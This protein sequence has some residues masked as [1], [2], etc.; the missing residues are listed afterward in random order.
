MSF[1]V[2]AG[3]AAC[4]AVFLV[5]IRER[6]FGF[7]SQKPTDYELT[8]P[9]FDLK[10][11][12]NGPM[13][14]EGVIYGP[15]GRVT[16]RFVG[17][18]EISWDGNRGEMRER[19]EYDNGDTQTRA[20]HLTLGPAGQVTARAEDVPGEGRGRILGSSLQLRYRIRLPEEAGGYVLSANDWMYLAPNNTIVNRSQFR[21]FGI[22]V[23]EL[24]ATM[25]PK[26][27]K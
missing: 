19:F 11:R 2:A 7:S 27:A 3:L 5:F 24:V 23:A 21:K 18:F 13:I 8:A 15:L 4:L 25:R 1:W 12:L 9:A 10:A 14:C 20:W 16:S 26:E 6:F 17:H 22:K